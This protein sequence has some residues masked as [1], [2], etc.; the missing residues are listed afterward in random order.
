MT[1]G[2]SHGNGPRPAARCG[3]CK[4]ELPDL[5]A[6]QC[7]TC[8]VD[9]HDAGIVAHT[10]LR[11]HI[12]QSG[13]VLGRRLR[14]QSLG[15]PVCGRCRYPVRGLIGFVCPECGSDV[16]AV[17]APRPRF[18]AGAVLLLV[19]GFLAWTG[20]WFAVVNGLGREFVLSRWAPH[21]VTANLTGS[22]ELAEDIRFPGQPRR[23]RHLL[24]ITI[25]TKLDEHLRRGQSIVVS[26]I[27]VTIEP[28]KDAAA[29]Q[30]APSARM[31]IDTVTDTFVVEYLTADGERSSRESAGIAGIDLALMHRVCD[32][33]GVTFAQPPPNHATMGTPDAALTGVAEQLHHLVSYE[34]TNRPGVGSR[35]GKSSSSGYSGNHYD[36]DS[37][38][39]LRHDSMGLAAWVM[40]VHYTV[41]TAIW[42]SGVLAV[43]LMLRR[44]RQ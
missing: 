26:P 36:L 37:T 41:L 25:D 34:R 23:E 42:L 31:S 33:L 19:F 32:H 40:P 22:I 12:R 35:G 44:R 43:W 20:L 17:G 29:Q 13:Y 24:S 9:L 2:P 14:R 3:A 1:E 5:S 27:E 7:P 16:R 18:S 10:S 6:W 28:G 38:F 11:E 21:H 39:D 4:A 15:E 30:P 8:G